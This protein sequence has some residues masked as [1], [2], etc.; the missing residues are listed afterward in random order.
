MKS[1]AMETR[2][3]SEAAKTT[4]ELPELLHR[5]LRVIAAVERRTI[6]EIVV[7]CLENCFG[8]VRLDPETFEVEAAPRNGKGRH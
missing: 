8:D 4:V 5:K 3:K 6:N 7:E 2:R 1:V